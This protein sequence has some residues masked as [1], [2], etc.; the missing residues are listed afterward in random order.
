M[1]KIMVT[2]LGRL[3]VEPVQVK[4]FNCCG[5]PLKNINLDAYLLSSARNLAIAEEKGLD[6]MTF[7]SCCYGSL[8]QVN[9]LMQTDETIRTRINRTLS[10]EGLAYGGTISVSH[11]LDFCYNHIGVERLK[12]A[13]THRLDGLKVAAH[14]GCQML[15]PRKIVGFDDPLTPT[16]F[17]QLVR[18]TGA[19]S[20]SYPNHLSCCGAPVCGVDTELSMDLAQRKINAAARAGADILCTVCA[21]CQVQFDKT[22]KIITLQREPSH[23]IPSISFSQLFGIALGIDLAFMGFDKHEFNAAHVFDAGG[24]S[25]TP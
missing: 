19:E 21:N 20:V 11:C 18:L 1:E 10:E 15:R 3:D 7:C 17:D 5:Y 2:M 4:E 12:S 13:V 9:H 22:Q 8:K 6:I 24:C 16:I 14:I 25:E 23:T